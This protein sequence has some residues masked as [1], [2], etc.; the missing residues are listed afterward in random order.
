MIVI[1]VPAVSCAGTLAL[2]TP[3]VISMFVPAVS[4][5]VAFI[6]PPTIVIPVPA[7]SCAGTLALIT[8]LV[9]SML[10][11]AVSLLARSLYDNGFPPIL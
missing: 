7:V 4:C 6:A 2:I 1:L 5:V 11:P 9:I 10:V 8:P 3:L